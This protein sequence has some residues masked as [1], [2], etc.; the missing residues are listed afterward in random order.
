[1][2]RAKLG[3][4][5]WLAFGAEI[6]TATAHCDALN[7]SAAVGTIFAYPVGHLELKVGSACRAI[8]TVIVLYA[9]TLM[10]NPG[11]KHLADGPVEPLCF[12]Y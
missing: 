12:L 10:A 7:G 11:P 8:G 6:G 3:L 2:T 5:C 4:G 1:M 9:G